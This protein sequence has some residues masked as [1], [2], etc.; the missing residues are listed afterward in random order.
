MKIKVSKYNEVAKSEL[1]RLFQEGARLIE[2]DSVGVG[3]SL[4]RY[5]VNGVSRFVYS[6]D[7]IEIHNVKLPLAD[8]DESY[9]SE[10]IEIQ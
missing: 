2:S 10:E 4:G 7:D 6:T 3:K 5:T 9:F 1:D 8:E